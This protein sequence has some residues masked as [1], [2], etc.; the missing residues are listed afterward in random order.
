MELSLEKEVLEKYPNAAIGYLVAKVKM[1]PSDPFVE[2][3]KS[4]LLTHLEG[5][6][7][8]ATNFA[9]HPSISIWREIYEK[10]FQ[11]KPKTYRSS[12]EA[13]LRRVITNKEMWKINNV[14]D[15]YNCCSILSLLPMGGYD[16]KKVQGNIKIRYAKDGETFIALGSK[17]RVQV[18]P[19]QVVYADDERIMCWLWNHKDSRDT[20][21]DEESE[22]VIFFMDAFDL[23]ELNK[24]L[25]LLKENL[26]KIESSVLEV[27]ILNKEAQS[28]ELKSFAVV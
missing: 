8:N 18:L 11:V 23:D 14:V 13:L 27:G 4:T 25:Q 12:L 21:I 28:I 7:I 22:Y 1:N 15:L 24:G 9:I 2:D 5:L 20:C 6:G 16:L 26:G 17:E 19:N 10:D 3:L